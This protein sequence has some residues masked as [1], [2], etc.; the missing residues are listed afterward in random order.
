MANDCARHAGIR[1][2]IYRRKLDE[3]MKILPENQ[4]GAGRHKCA[5]CAW[6]RGF[7]EGYRHGLRVAADAL[8]TLAEEQG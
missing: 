6:E 1:N 7:D 2:E 4:S 3:M 5:Y 8:Q